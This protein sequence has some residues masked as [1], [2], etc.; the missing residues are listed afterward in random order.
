MVIGA[1]SAKN[2]RSIHGVIS[3]KLSKT[4]GESVSAI[5]PQFTFPGVASIPRH[6]AD[7]IVTEYG[8]A[9]L[10]GKS[11]R[12]RAEELISIAH[13]DVRAEL[14][15]EARKLFYPQS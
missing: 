12:Q 5:V 13:P 6:F 4:T 10:L 9:S 7:F 11:E 2:G 8:I 3:R 14:R 15:K 1:M